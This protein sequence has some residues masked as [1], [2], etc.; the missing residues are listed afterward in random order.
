MGASIARERELLAEIR[1]EADVIIDTSDMS[2][3][4]LRERL[5]GALDTPTTTAG[6]HPAAGQ[7][8]L[9]ERHSA[10]GR[11]GLRRALHGEPVLHRR[12]R[13][14]NGLDQDVREFVLGQPMTPPLSRP[15]QRLPRACTLPGYETEGRGRLTVAFGCTGGQH[16][17]IAIAEEVAARMARERAAGQRLA[18]RA[19]SRRERRDP[20][21]DPRA[22]AAPRSRRR[23][24]GASATQ[25][26]RA[27]A[28]PGHRRQALAG[29][30]LR[31]PAADRAGGRAGA[32]DTAPMTQPYD[33][34][35]DVF[36]TSTLQACR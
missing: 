23:C 11:H 22:E 16:R 13:P 14:L 31:R 9:Q 7:L 26:L 24:A 35:H 21:A 17:S 32:H 20:T 36:E 2:G 28:A 27:L 12:L 15:G 8:R 18:P 29:G 25:V 4:Q 10:R 30:R 34:G 6:R 5:Y 1:A 33:P 19:R 3:R